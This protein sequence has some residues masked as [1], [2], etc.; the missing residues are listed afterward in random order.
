MVKL[1]RNY[2][3]THYSSLPQGIKLKHRNHA[4][5]H[6]FDFTLFCF[7]NKDSVFRFKVIFTCSSGLTQFFGKADLF[8]LCNAFYLILWFL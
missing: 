1:L 3:H 6:I 5:I 2:L 4:L 8:W 7:F